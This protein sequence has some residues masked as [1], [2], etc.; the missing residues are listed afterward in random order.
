MLPAM[1]AHGVPG[2]SRPLRGEITLEEAI[3]RGQADTR[4]YAKR[5][6]T[7]F[8]HQMPDFSWVTPEEAFGAAMRALAGGPPGTKR[9]ACEEARQRSI[10]P[11][12]AG[13][14]ISRVP[15]Q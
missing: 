7:W 14:S 11:S 13:P 6:F 12:V 2:P 10:P 3:A 4:R 9:S 5:Q 15:L 8:R 1:R